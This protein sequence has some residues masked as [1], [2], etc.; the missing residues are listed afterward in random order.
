MDAR[1]GGGMTIH[2][3]AVYLVRFDQPPSAPAATAGA[4]DD[5]PEIEPLAASPPPPDEPPPPPARSEEEILAEA[6]TKFK[7]ALVQE[8]EAFER[9]LEEERARWVKEQG[10]ALGREFARSQEQSM[11]ALRADVARILSPFVSREIVD[12]VLEDLIAAMRRGLANE[13]SPLVSVSA[14]RDLLAQEREYCGRRAAQRTC[15]RPRR[16]RLND[17]GIAT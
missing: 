6:E 15:R 10:E 7:A 3:A 11:T 12:R 8:R 4:N 17:P 14:P 13:E 1:Q 2:S 16:L 9:R 5:A